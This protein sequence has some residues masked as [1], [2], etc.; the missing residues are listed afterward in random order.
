MSCLPVSLENWA[1]S[2]RANVSVPPPGG[3]GTTSVTG[4]DGQVDWASAASGSARALAVAVAVA[5][6][7]MSRR[8]PCR[9]MLNVMLVSCNCE[10]LLTP[11]TLTQARA[12][13]GSPQSSGYWQPQA[14]CRAAQRYN[15][16]P[17]ST[18][19]THSH[20]PML[21]PKDKIPR[22]ASGSRK[23]S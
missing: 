10:Y 16:R 13:R 1:D 22:W 19:G 5:A 17:P 8:V 18:M 12:P 7:N 6:R 21:M 3:N 9:A 2:G 15:P 20:W 11:R 4:L 14:F 23:N